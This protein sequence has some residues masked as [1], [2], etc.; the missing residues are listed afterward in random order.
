M[1]QL[2]IGTAASIACV[3]LACSL[4]AQENVPIPP[5]PPPP[6]PDGMVIKEDGMA[7]KMIAEAGS[8]EPK[9]VT[10]APYS[11]DQTTTTT[12]TLS[13]GNR[14][15]HT[16]T[17]KM[18]RD[19][20]GR[21][22]IERN[23]GNIGAVA[24]S[25]AHTIISINDPVA[26]IR[27]EL[28]P[29]ERTAQKMSGAPL[30][31]QMDTKQRAEA[32]VLGGVI[33]SMTATPSGNLSFVTM[34]SSGDGPGGGFVY[35]TESVRLAGGSKPA[36]EDL[37]VQTMEGLQ[38][39]GTRTTITIPAGAEGNERP[40]QIIDERWYSPDLKTAVKT[41]HSD[42]RMGE[43]VFTLGNVSR[44]NPDASL[45]QVPA[46]YQVTDGPGDGKFLF[47]YTTTAPPPPA[48]Q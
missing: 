20:Q 39:K 30:K 35:H 3:F 31:K 38:V 25:D 8:L 47:R 9:T 34:D 19:D 6:G 16:S 26:G 5:P 32:G 37:G 28:Q 13:D 44:T 4:C 43:T 23:I 2:R 15:V 1:K 14:I 36:I 11:A 21:T 10:L 7:I 41:I 24:T 40:M 29:G 48:N 45:F 42:P 18:Y 17:A 22:R 46:D 27:Y 12:Q 33:G